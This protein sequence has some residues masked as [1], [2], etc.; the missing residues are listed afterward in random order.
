MSFTKNGMV[1]NNIEEMDY[2]LVVEAI[3]MVK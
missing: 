2:L 3:I 1:K